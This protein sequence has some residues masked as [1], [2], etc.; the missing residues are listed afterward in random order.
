MKRCRGNPSNLLTVSHWM[1]QK[2]CNLSC[3]VRCRNSATTSPLD[4]AEILLPLTHWMLQK[5]CDHLYT[6]CCRN[7]AT[8]HTLSVAE[9][10]HQLIHWVSQKFC[11]NSYAGC[12]RNSQGIAEC[13]RMSQKHCDQRNLATIFSFFQFSPMNWKVM[14]NQFIKDFFFHLKNR[15]S[16]F[17][18]LSLFNS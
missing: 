18:T 17:S 2:F 14:E 5:F 8:T 4:V 6:G 12:C 11:D 9:I 13:H 1:L 10:L 3:T 16:V 15:L 7:S